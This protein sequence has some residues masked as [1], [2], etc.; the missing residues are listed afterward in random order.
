MENET[1]TEQNT[2][3]GNEQSSE[4]QSN[5][6]WKNDSRTLSIT[7]QLAKY[8]KAEADR[9]EAEANAQKQAEME[10]AKAEGR[11]KDAEK[12]HAEALKSLEEQF[13]AKILERDLGLEMAKAGFSNKKFVKGAISDYNPEEH[14]SP[15]DYVKALMAD[16]ENKPFLSTG[17]PNVPAAPG[18]PGF[19]GGEPMNKEK[20]RAM[21]KSDDPKER[22]AA[23]KYVADY[24]DKHNALPDWLKR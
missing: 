21:Q 10:K 16:E 15:E 9:K 13:A 2:E 19:G 14:T 12:M 20:Y 6:D 24:F 5:N 11:W 23:Q 4:K 17:K 1:G 8:Q 18:K 22:A 7:S 3:Q